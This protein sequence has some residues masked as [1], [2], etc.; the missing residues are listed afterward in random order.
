MNES[1]KSAA[2]TAEQQV[3]QRKAR[4]VMLAIVAVFVL[5]FIVL[6]LF[7]S[8][9]RAGKT[10]KGWLIQPHIPLAELAL[11]HEQQAV[12]ES[13]LEKRWILLYVIPETCDAVCITARN[14]A[15]YAMRQVRLSL[16]RSVDRVQQLLVYTSGLDGPLSALLEKEFSVMKTAQGNRQTLE[17]VLFSRLPERYPAGNIFLMSPDGYVFMSYPTFADEEES[18]LRARDIRADLKKSIKGDRNF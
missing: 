15:L 11:T 13:Y 9:E 7:S 5:P 18:V 4:L 6:P 2:L 3:Q 17:Q 1:L 8:P 16:D 14:N 12:T 10:N